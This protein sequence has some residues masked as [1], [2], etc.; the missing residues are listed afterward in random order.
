MFSIFF[1]K[2]NKHA[3]HAFGILVQDLLLPQ[4]LAGQQ[5]KRRESQLIRTGFE[6]TTSLDSSK[7]SFGV[8][9]FVPFELL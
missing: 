8:E 3:L 7:T 2:L 1:D 9:L 5:W 6:T 4:E